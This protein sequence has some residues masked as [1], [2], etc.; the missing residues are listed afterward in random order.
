M[1]KKSNRFLPEMRERAVM[2]Q[3]S[4]AAYEIDQFLNDFSTASLLIKR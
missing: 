1:N 3:L 2:Q 4:K